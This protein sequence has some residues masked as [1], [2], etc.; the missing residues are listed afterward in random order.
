[1]KEIRNILYLYN[2]LS[3]TTITPK[4]LR[5]LLLENCSNQ[6]HNHLIDLQNCT[7][8]T[9]SKRRRSVSD[10]QDTTVSDMAT[11]SSGPITIRLN[12]GEKGQKSEMLKHSVLH[13]FILMHSI[14]IMKAE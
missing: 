3:N 2:H 12:K 14:K 7:T 6:N 11:V 4:Q 1:M 10:N 9:N 13:Q 5:L 8:N